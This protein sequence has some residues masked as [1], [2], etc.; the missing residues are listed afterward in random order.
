MR[1]LS[2]V[3]LWSAMVLLLV[4]GSTFLVPR[5]HARP[6]PTPAAQAKKTRNKKRATK[7]RKTKMILKGHRG[8]HK[9]KPA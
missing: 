5:A 2:R 9:R 4:L 3:A 1:R 7:P 8:Q 6:V